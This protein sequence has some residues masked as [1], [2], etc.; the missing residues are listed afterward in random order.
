MKPAI[1]EP[2]EKIIVVSDL[3]QWANHSHVKTWDE[4]KEISQNS[5]FVLQANQYQADE[6]GVLKKLI[7][8]RCYCEGK[9]F[10]LNIR[11]ISDEVV[12]SIM[13][14]QL[15]NQWCARIR[16]N[17]R[18][19]FFGFESDYTMHQAQLYSDSVKKDVAQLGLIDAIYSNE[20][21][22]ARPI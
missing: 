9:L 2:G 6:S 21:L 13:P 8:H 15:H 18:E 16:T 19:M 1:Y 17:H 11:L 5:E 3:T 20:C 4:A 14:A 22:V 7:E 10:I 12:K